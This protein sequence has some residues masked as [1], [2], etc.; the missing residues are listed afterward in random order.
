[1][2]MD[3]IIDRDGVKGLVNRAFG[4]ASSHGF[5]DE[6]HT[7]M[8]YM[9]LVLS[10]VGEMVEADRK[11]RHAQLS[12]FEEGIRQPQTKEHEQAHWMFVF[13]TFIK[14]TLEDELADVVIRMLDYL[15]DRKY[16]IRAIDDLEYEFNE[17]FGEYTTVE[18]CFFL[19]K[20]ITEIDDVA[21]EGDIIN[22]VYCILSFCFIFA[23]LHGIDLLRHVDL[24][25]T[26]N[27]QRARKHGKKY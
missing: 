13:E 6:A 24:K 20:L 10:E 2:R 4:I 7:N 15:G 14:D 18:R 16:E 22:N 21:L 19:S 11:S 3:V 23:R 12:M 9:M 5:H 27:E 17:C 26:Y 25:M 8:H 1:M